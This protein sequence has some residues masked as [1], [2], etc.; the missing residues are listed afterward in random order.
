MK[1]RSITVGLAVLTA[2]SFGAVLAGCGSSA[3][4]ST[5]PTSTPAAA[6]PTTPTGG[7]ETVS[8]EMNEFSY[9]P[10]DATAKAGSV[11][12]DAPNTGAEPHEL[13]LAK[14]DADPAK[15]PTTSDGSVDEESLDSPG[16]I[17]E[18]EGGADGTVTLD[19]KAG[20]YVMFCNLPGHYAAGMYGTFTVN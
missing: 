19:L 13:V 18:V 2:V 10:S 14:T 4:S 5:T 20:K 7:D 1:L 15:L 12:I 6:E 3:D 17:P 16:E 9:L 8:I 11:T